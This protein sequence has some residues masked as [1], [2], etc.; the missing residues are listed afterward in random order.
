[1]RVQGAQ[2]NRALKT[3]AEQAEAMQKY[4]LE[5]M[6]TDSSTWVRPLRRAPAPKY[7]WGKGSMSAELTTYSPNFEPCPVANIGSDGQPHNYNP[8]VYLGRLSGTAPVAEHAHADSWEVLFALEADGTMMLDGVPRHVGPKDIVKVPPKAKH[9]WQPAPVLGWSR[10]RRTLRRGRKSGSR[11]SPR[12]HSCERHTAPRL[13]A[14]PITAVVRRR[15]SWQPPL[16]GRTLISR[17]EVVSSRPCC[18]GAPC[19]CRC[20][21]ANR[22]LRVEIARCPQGALVDLGAEREVRLAGER[23]GLAARP[24]LR[25]ARGAGKEARGA[26]CS[27]S[28]A[29]GRNHR[30]RRRARHRPWTDWRAVRRARFDGRRRRRRPVLS[31]GWPRAAG[32]QGQRGGAEEAPLDSNVHRG[33]RPEQ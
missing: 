29:P 15:E 14:A 32:G 18:R 23:R 5:A 11:T 4:L 20:N 33:V 10:Y 30:V 26:W 24:R 7:T 12:S 28:A 17:Y 3:V 22:T 9:S 31:F 6:G 19:P 13:R 25:R 2:A 16:H 21:G 8:V 1:M 27:R